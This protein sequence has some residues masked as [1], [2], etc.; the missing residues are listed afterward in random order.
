MSSTA[1]CKSIWPAGLRP[2][3][4]FRVR[5]ACGSFVG[6]ARA[7]GKRGGCRVIYFWHAASSRL[8]MLFAFSKS[9]RV[10]L[11][12]AQKKALRVI[13]ETEYR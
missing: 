13:V 7:G 5:E 2:G 9:E 8:L 10:D 3:T 12:A 1:G 4:S 11:T 6:L